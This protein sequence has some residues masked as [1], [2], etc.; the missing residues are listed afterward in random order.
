MIR[1]KNPLLSLVLTFV[2]V[3]SL[4]APALATEEMVAVNET[5][6][7]DATFRSYVAK[8]FDTNKDN[9]LSAAERNGVAKIDVNP[10]FG[11]K[12]SIASLKGIEFFPNLNLNIS[13][14]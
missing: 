13:K 6:F 3:L 1:R 7:P 5:N 2:L 8:N 4:A 10:G 14:L 9:K 11:S 12:G